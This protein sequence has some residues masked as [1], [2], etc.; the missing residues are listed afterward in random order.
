VGVSLK[1][2]KPQ[3]WCFFYLLVG[4]AQLVPDARRKAFVCCAYLCVY[5]YGD[6]A[7]G[8]IDS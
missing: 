7:M 8:D 6:G 4:E 2:K 5:V 3:C 1:G